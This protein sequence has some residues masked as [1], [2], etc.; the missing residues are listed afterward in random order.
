[1][2]FAGKAHPADEWG[3]RLLQD[4]FKASRTEALAGRVVL[5]EDYD[6]RMASNL[7]RGCDVWL[8]TPVHLMEASGTSGMKAAM[9][10]AL[11]LSVLDGWWAEGHNGKNGWA[12]GAPPAQ[13]FSQLAEGQSRLDLDDEA[14]SRHLNVLLERVILPMFHAQGPARPS[15][16]WGER[17]L[18]ALVS[19]LSRFSATRMLGDYTRDHY[20]PALEREAMAQADSFAAMRAVC[21]SKRNLA[22][23]FAALEIVDA[24]VDP[25]SDAQVDLGQSVDVSVLVKH[26]G[27]QPD[28]LRVEFVISPH[29]RRDQHDRLMASALQYEGRDDRG[30][31]RWHGSFCP[32]HSGP[33]SWGIRVLPSVGLDPRQSTAFD[34]AFVKWL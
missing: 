17:S 1:F 32:S 12:I 11:N 26:P 27:I 2:L 33:H 15:P 23:A 4:V 31:G 8:N 16:E 7:V 34:F 5:L 20:R 24:Q 30:N 18:E 9:N 19:A 29:D 3:K 25:L 10:G 14:D 28:E 22:A 21:A 13:Y 6:L